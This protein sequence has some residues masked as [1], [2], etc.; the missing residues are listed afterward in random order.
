MGGLTAYL[1]AQF[2]MWEAP[3][4]IGFLLAL[5]LFFPAFIVAVIGPENLREPAT[6]A[7]IG[8]VITAQIIFMWAN[9]HMVT[10]FTLAQRHYRAGA[11]DEARSVLEDLRS[12][13]KANFQA[14]TLLGNTY[15]QLSRLEESETVL[16]EALDM[17]PNHYFPRYGFGRTLLVKGQYQEAAE[18]IEAALDADAPAVV[19]FDLGEAHYRL[20]NDESAKTRLTAALPHLEDQPP[21]YLMAVY[22]LHRLGA[23]DAPDADLIR[24]NLAYWR[25]QAERFADT[26][27]GQALADDVGGLQSLVERE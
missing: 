20:Q 14:L 1:I 4:R 23:H 13:D 5:V 27:Y 3:A 18:A 11:F 9:R 17:A 19:Q 12:G 25:A 8:L 10:P 15:R 22:L 26:P 7:T 6:I 2:K 24:E 16:L 21:R